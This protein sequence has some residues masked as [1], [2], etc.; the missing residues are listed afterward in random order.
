MH[1]YSILIAAAATAFGFVATAGSFSGVDAVPLSLIN[2]S[3]NQFT[4]QEVMVGQWNHN[5]DKLTTNAGHFTT[6]CYS[7]TK[8]ANVPD[9]IGTLKLVRN[10]IVVGNKQHQFHCVS[11]IHMGMEIGSTEKATGILAL[12]GETALGKVPNLVNYVQ[13][14]PWFSSGTFTYA[15]YIQSRDERMIG[16]LRCAFGDVDVKTQLSGYK[17]VGLFKAGK[18]HCSFQV[19]S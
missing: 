15:T 3:K 14:I 12:N 11:Y 6:E 19:K 13:V 16:Y 5:L 7:G 10:N 1:G 2:K 17:P 8:P 4:A 18:A 9:T